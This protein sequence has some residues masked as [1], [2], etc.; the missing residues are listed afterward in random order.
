MT[1]MI[2]QRLRL[3]ISKVEGTIKLAGKG[4]TAPLHG[5]AD[6]TVQHGTHTAKIR[7]R[8]LETSGPE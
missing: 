6:A 8:L 5:M 3:D 1:P 4:T 2:A 7:F